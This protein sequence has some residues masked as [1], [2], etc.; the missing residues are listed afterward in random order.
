MHLNNQAAGKTFVSPLTLRSPLQAC[1]SSESDDL[2]TRYKFAIL[3]S[4]PTKRVTSAY[5]KLTVIIKNK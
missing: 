5:C 3:S 1:Y 2:H 4:H